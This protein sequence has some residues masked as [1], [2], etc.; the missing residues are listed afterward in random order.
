M[1]PSLARLKCPFWVFGAASQGAAPRGGGKV[2]NLPLVFHFST[3][4]NLRKWFF[5]QRPD[6]RSRG[7]GNVGISR[8]RRDFQG[9]VGR[10]E[11]CR[12]VFHPFHRPV[13][14]T[15]PSFSR[16]SVHPLIPLRLH[17]HRRPPRMSRS[18]FH[19]RRMKR[20]PSQLRLFRLRHPLV[21][22]PPHQLLALIHQP[23]AALPSLLH[24]YRRPGR[25]IHLRLPFD[26]QQPV[27]LRSALGSHR[28]SDFDQHP[29]RRRVP[30]TKCRSCAWGRVGIYG[31]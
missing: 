30:R 3:A 22:F 20:S 21:D 7:C 4:H 11:N 31:R 29:P 12:L 26:L 9:A 8:C 23:Q 6:R 25:H 10:V 5:L 28:R 13:I 16:D 17:H 18:G 19:S 15:A 24:D 1:S 27:P 14:S 2:E